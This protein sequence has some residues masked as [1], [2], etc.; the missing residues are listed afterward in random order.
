MY[1]EEIKNFKPVRP[2]NSKDIER[3]ADLS[4]VTIVNLKEANRIEELKDGMMYLKLLKKLPAQKYWSRT[5]VGYMKT[6]GLSV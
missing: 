5:T 1:L 6:T 2:G 4:D 3:Y